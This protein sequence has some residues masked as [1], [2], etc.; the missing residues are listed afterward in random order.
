MASSAGSSGTE[1]GGLGLD[2]DGCIDRMGFAGNRAE[3]LG[4]I[5]LSGSWVW[6]DGVKNDDDDS[7]V[8]V[9]FSAALFLFRIKGGPQNLGSIGAQKLGTTVP[10]NW[11]PIGFGRGE[12]DGPRTV[13]VRLMS[14]S[15]I[16]TTWSKDAG[17]ATGRLVGRTNRTN[18]IRPVARARPAG[19]RVALPPAGQL[20]AGQEGGQGVLADSQGGH[21]FLVAGECVGLLLGGPLEAECE[22]FEVGIASQLGSVEPV[23]IDEAL[24]AA[25][26]DPGLSECG[27]HGIALPVRGRHGDGRCARGAAQRAVI[28]W[29]D[30][31]GAV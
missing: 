30:R 27:T 24:P 31:A 13:L 23:V 12:G 22:A 11:G 16:L 15:M 25:G 7:P 1:G 19:I 29:R 2:M 9:V 4:A 8:V 28:P 20:V 5:R 17:V 14:A 21:E 10:R 6:W 26:V 18:P 3:G